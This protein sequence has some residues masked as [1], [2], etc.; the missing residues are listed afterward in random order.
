MAFVVAATW[1]AKEGE[2]KRVEETIVKMTPLSR[3]EEG[4]LFY[5]AQGH[6]DDPRTF[7]LYEQYVDEAG[8]EAH[9]ATRA[10][11]GE[12]VRL[13]HRVPRG[14]LGEDV[15]DDRR[16][17]R[18]PRRESLLSASRRG[19]LSPRRRPRD[20][21]RARCTPTSGRALAGR[22]EQPDHACSTEVRV[23]PA[24]P[25]RRSSAGIADPAR[26][27]GPVD[28]FALRNPDMYVAGTRV[29]MVSSPATL[30]EQVPGM[31]TEQA[32]AN[33]WWSG[34]FSAPDRIGWW[35]GQ[36]QPPG[37]NADGLSARIASSPAA[38]RTPVRYRPPRHRRHPL[39]AAARAAAAPAPATT[40]ANQATSPARASASPTD[41]RPSTIDG[42]STP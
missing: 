4:N 28:S 38:S 6:P 10:L 20:R 15:P 33:P 3:A 13:H 2:E 11:P 26:V 40:R 19:R 27:H 31:T 32:Q 22:F 5:Q 21:G 39:A 23:A 36:E 37:E 9:K 16:L 25:P 30:A 8:Y 35:L 18:C 7:F 12:R 41:G 24:R 14:A 1:M 17:S 34:F 29:N 42:V